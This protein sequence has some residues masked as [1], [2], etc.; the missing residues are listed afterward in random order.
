MLAPTSRIF[1]ALKPDPFIAISLF[2]AEELP[3]VSNFY[4]IQFWQFET[5][6]AAF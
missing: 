4:F 3:N 1:A 5:A 6:L 2:S